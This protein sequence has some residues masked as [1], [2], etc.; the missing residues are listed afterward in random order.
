MARIG[1]L[2]VGG[3]LAVLA[4]LAWAPAARAQ[5]GQSTPGVTVMAQNP[6]TDRQG[7]DLRLTLVAHTAASTVANPSCRPQDATLRCW[8][9]LVLRLPAAGGLAL[10]GL[11]VHRV[12][13]GD[14]SCGDESGDSCSDGGM[15]APASTTFP[16]QAQVNGLSVLTDPGTSG[17]PVGTTVQVQITLTDTGTAHDLATAEVQVR[18][19]V[20]GPNKPLIVDTGPQRIQQVQIHRDGSGG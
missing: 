15:A 4:L 18:Q 9:D 10:Q 17:L 19:F 5:S 20:P 14:I 6:G 16:L 2:K 7:S 13:V 1:T 8:G 11:E 12:A 3:L